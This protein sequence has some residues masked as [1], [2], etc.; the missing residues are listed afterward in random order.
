[1][2]LRSGK[3]KDPFLA[4]CARNIW[5]CAAT[6]DVDASY[7]HIRGTNNK[8]ADL[9]SRWTGNAKDCQSLLMHVKDPWW[10]SVNE[11]MLAFYP[12]L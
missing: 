11:D 3:T 9:L 12:D 1:M 8:V 10:L 4:A 5:Y 2:V 6:N 7:A